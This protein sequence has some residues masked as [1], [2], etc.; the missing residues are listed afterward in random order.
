MNNVQSLK[1]SLHSNLTQN[2]CYFS[3]LILEDY[4]VE[5]ALGM[6]EI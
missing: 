6:S 1:D 2:L 5:I 4:L 3:F